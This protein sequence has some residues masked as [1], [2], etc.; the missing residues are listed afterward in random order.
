MALASRVILGSESDETHEYI[1]L[2]VLGAFKLLASRG[3][4]EILYRHLPRSG[5]LFIRLRF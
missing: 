5:G 4:I 3:S 2:T 1:L